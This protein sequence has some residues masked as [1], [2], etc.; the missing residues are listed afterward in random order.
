[1]TPDLWSVS[2]D[3]IE[4]KRRL[5]ALLNDSR[6]AIPTERA[7]ERGWPREVRI[8]SLSSLEVEAEQIRAVVGVAFVECFGTGCSEHYS[9]TPRWAECRVVVEKATGNIAYQLIESENAPEF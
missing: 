7:C 2:N 9:T 1:M 3:L 5:L 6:A 8:E 4:L